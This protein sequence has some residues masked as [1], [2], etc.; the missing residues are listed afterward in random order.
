[1]SPNNSP[2][3]ISPLPLDFRKERQGE[4]TN[5]SEASSIG[6]GEV[7]K[8]ILPT[9]TSG[10]VKLPQSL[11]EQERALEAVKPQNTELE[12]VKPTKPEIVVK[13]GLIDASSIEKIVGANRKN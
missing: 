5:I 2:R 6:R 7:F 1:M 11:E 13:D 4:G 9:E 3:E 10:E 12:A 8:P